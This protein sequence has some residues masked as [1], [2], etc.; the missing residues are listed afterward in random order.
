MTGDPAQ[1]FQKVLAALGEFGLLMVSDRGFPSVSGLVAGEPV[2]GSWWSHPLAHTI[3]GV[4]EILEDHKDVLITKLI[5][6]KVTFVH[7]SMWP[8]VYA[9]GS[10]REKW[11][12]EGLSSAAITLFKKLQITG[13]LNTNK[14][15]PVRGIKPGDIA[16][17]LESRLLIHSEQV[18][19]GSGAHA[20]TIETWEHWADRVG[21]KARRS[22]PEKA[23]QF[24][25]KRVK[26]L[27][28]R[29]GARG[30]LPWLQANIREQT[31]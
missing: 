7:R 13:T 16:R 4:N 19:T 3:F 26:E 31:P 24:L 8:H 6:G 30:G 29:F 14:L 25:E 20:K 1:E 5:G 28:E 12:M 10:A 27:N 15:D 11:Q 17:E 2:K 21:L 18:H 9:I 23:R 22:D